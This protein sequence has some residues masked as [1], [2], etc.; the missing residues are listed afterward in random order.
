MVD[1]GPTGGVTGPGRIDRPPRVN[2][3]PPSEPVEPSN[4]AEDRV[5]IS[6]QARLLSELSGFPRVRQ[7]RVDQLRR[8]VESGRYETPEKLKA[9]LGRFLEQEEGIL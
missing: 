4:P 6:E 5:E 8:E 7:D 3:V 1:I 9:A 2:R